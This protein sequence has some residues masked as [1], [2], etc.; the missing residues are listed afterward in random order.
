MSDATSNS[1]PDFCGSNSPRFGVVAIG[2]NEGERFERC[3]HSLKRE[4]AGRAIVIVYVDSGSTDNSVAFA[5]SQRVQV[6]NLDMSR[7]FTAARAR[8]AGLERLLQVS[9]HVEFVQFID[10]DCEVI[11]GWLDAAASVFAERHE[12]VALSGR[13]RERFPEKSLYNRLADIEWERPVG[14]TKSCGGVAMMRVAAVQRAGGFDPTLI[15]GEEPELCARM[16][17]NG[18]TILN[19]AHEMAW[20]DMAM[21]TSAQWYKRARRHGHAIIEVSSFK[22]EA[23]RGLFAKQMRSAVLWSSVLLFA[24]LVTLPVVYMFAMIIVAFAGGYRLLEVDT[25]DRWLNRLHSVQI[26]IA[27]P[28]I[29]GVLAGAAWLAQCWRIA[30]RARREKRLTNREALS[31]GG[32]TMCSKIANVRG[33]LDFLWRRWRKRDATIISYKEPV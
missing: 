29:V 25:A 5:Q 32:L 13:L 1:G 9:P 19:I 24:F 7:S 18:G 26:A 33:M 21:T 11:E 22:S 23:S 31:F 6:V 12:V 15:A 20:H 27:A 28:G 8:N 30:I 17:A 16:R 3:V 2:R 4:A 10:G 14:E